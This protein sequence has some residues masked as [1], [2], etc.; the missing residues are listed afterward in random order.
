MIIMHLT[1]FC[2]S[3][4]MQYFSKRASALLLCQLDSSALNVTQ[5][6]TMTLISM[7]RQREYAA[8]L[9]LCSPK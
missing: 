1:N 3:V 4:L 9:S 8:A 7:Q 5:L 2:Q 6:G